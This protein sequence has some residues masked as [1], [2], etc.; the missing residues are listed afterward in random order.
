MTQI[1][2]CLECGN[3]RGILGPC[4]Y[5][6]AITPPSFGTDSVE[7][8]IKEGSPTVEEALDRL[9]DNIRQFEAL[10]IKAIVLIHGYGSSGEGGLIKRAIHEALE[11]NRFADRVED[12]YFGEQVS[13]GS[14]A[15]QNLMKRRP[16]LRRFIGRFKAGNAGIS[17]LLLGTSHRNA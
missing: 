6:Q 10:G 8:N 17:I 9:T 15:Y 3:A 14:Q 7:F 13:F 11:N 4:P 16:G 12:Y 5:C 2:Q 1:A